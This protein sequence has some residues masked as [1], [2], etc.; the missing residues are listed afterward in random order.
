MYINYGFNMTPLTNPADS[1][2]TSVL[3]PLTKLKSLRKPKFASNSY[4]NLLACN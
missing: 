1:G 4:D 2:H 3:F